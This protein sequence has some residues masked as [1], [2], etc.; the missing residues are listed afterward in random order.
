[1]AFMRAEY[2]WL[3]DSELWL[4]AGKRQPECITAPISLN[5]LPVFSFLRHSPLHPLFSSSASYDWS[6]TQTVAL[7]IRSSSISLLQSSLTTDKMGTIDSSRRIVSPI[8]QEEQ[9]YYIG[10]NGY[11]LV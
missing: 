8:L 11:W 5:L 4:W 3:K 9:S 6:L 10:A 7:C 2:R 1:M